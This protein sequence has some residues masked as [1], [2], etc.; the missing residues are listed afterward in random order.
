ME[1]ASRACECASGTG[2][3]ADE[4]SSHSTL[5]RPTPTLFAR[6]E[7]V[8]LVVFRPYFGPAIE[9]SIRYRNI[10]SKNKYFCAIESVQVGRANVRVTPPLVRSLTRSTRTL[11]HTTYYSHTRTQ[12][13]RRVLAQDVS[14]LYFTNSIPPATARLSQARPSSMCRENT[15]RGLTASA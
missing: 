15:V 5:V 6:A 13:T 4:W 10:R 2:E 9:T 14:L 7:I 11:T 3:R 8:V 12:C 1:C